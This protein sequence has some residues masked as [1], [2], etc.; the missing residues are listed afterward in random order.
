MESSG[1]HPLSLNSS[2]GEPCECLLCSSLFARDTTLDKPLDRPLRQ[3]D[4]VYRR[5]ISD[6]PCMRL[7][8]LLVLLLS[9]FIV[10]RTLYRRT[11]ARTHRVQGSRRVPFPSS[12][13][14]AGVAAWRE[15]RLARDRSPFDRTLASTYCKNKRHIHRS[16]TFLPGTISSF[17]G[18]RASSAS[19]FSRGGG[20]SAMYLP[21]LVFSRHCGR[22]S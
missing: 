12:P 10:A 5:G 16:L 15:L 3:I 2:S 21:R 14:L 8:V 18:F 19:C 20:A 22:R 1:S 17:P 7:S 9:L 4:S 13:S 11:H 6:H